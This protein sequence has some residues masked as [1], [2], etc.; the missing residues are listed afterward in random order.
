MSFHLLEQAKLAK[1]F[2][3]QV[4]HVAGAYLRFL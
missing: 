4:A 1:S 2:T 3:S